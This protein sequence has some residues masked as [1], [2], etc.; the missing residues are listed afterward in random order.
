MVAIAEIYRHERISVIRPSFAIVFHEDS[1]SN[2]IVCATRHK[3]NPDTHTLSIGTIVSAPQIAKTFS[4]LKV[5]KS[6]Q[7]T[8]CIPENVIYESDQLLVWF[9]RRFVGDMWFRHGSK[10]QRLNVEWPPLLF[11][12]L[13]K[14]Q[15]MYVFALG[16]NSRPNE[17]SVLY[18][19]PFMNINERGHLCQGTAHLPIDLSTQS[20]TECEST[21]FDSQFTHVN[22][23]YTF[24]HKTDNKTHFS[25]WKSKAKTRSRVPVRLMTKE[26]SLTGFNVQDFIQEH[27]NG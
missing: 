21:L 14:K 27:M 23:E 5:E 12:L 6:K 17:N 19:A 13:K 11:A 26:L 15:S 10:P 24:R 18:N 22:H 16:K 8:V 1:L 20:I 3:V 9:K 2:S 7:N 4:E 25:F